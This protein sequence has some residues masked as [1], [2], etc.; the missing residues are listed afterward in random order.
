MVRR[1]EDEDEVEGA[2]PTPVDAREYQRSRAYQIWS[3]SDT[4]HELTVEE[5]LFCRSYIVDRNEVAAMRRLGYGDELTNATL[6]RRAERMLANPEVQGCIEVLARKMMDNLQIEAENVN[7]TMAAIAFADPRQIMEWDSNGVQ[8]LHS[9]YLTREQ[10]LSLKSVKMGKEGI[11]IEFADRQRA[12]E[13]LGKQLG[14][15]NDENELARAAAEGAA[16]GAMDKI[17]EIT[18]RMRPASQQVVEGSTGDS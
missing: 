4:G 12:L 6:K 9:K 3:Y 7:R 10:A 15:S 5:Q 18:E 2:M 13:F 17:L 14:V 1:G 16:R 11:Q 8:L